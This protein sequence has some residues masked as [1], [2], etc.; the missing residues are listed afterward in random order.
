[1]KIT[2][3]HGISVNISSAGELG[4]L[5]K[6]INPGDSVSASVI[7]SE[8]NKAQLEIGGRI[9]SAEFT[10]GVPGEKIIELVLT[11][12]SLE[13]IQFE[14]K[15]SET[16]G[17]L[18]RFLSPFSIMQE[19]EIKKSSLQNLARFINNSK[20]D[21]LEINL[22]LLGLKRDERKEKT[23]PAFFNHLL[24]KGIPF[25]VLADIATLVYSKYNPAVFSAYQYMLSLT[26]KKTVNFKKEDKSSLHESIDVFSGFMKDDDLDF[27]LMLELLSDENKNSGIYGEMAFPEDEGFSGMEYVVKPESVFLKFDFSA[28]GTLCVFIKAEKGEFVI[29]FL[30][31]KDEAL[32]LIKENE[33]ILKK[34]LEQRGIKKSIIGYF[35]SKKIVD[36]LELWSLDFYTKSGFNVKV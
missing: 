20:P 27:S 10:N 16:S 11:S 3:N 30:S 9:I 26:G 32:L 12:K 2:G 7:R 5:F 19:D 18:F 8:G 25:H 6:N 22:F 33:G 34:M 1:M 17:K 36:K 15:D 24:Q 23:G 13:K 35:D 4:A 28:V 31:L 14:L 21:L 29:N